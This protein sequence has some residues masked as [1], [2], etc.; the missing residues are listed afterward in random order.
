MR[1]RFAQ[2]GGF[3]GMSREVAVDTSNLNQGEATELEQLVREA[4]LQT[5]APPRSSLGRDLEEYEIS[6]DDG[7][8]NVT[9]VLEQSTVPL[10][11]RRLV[12]HLK[13][14]TKPATPISDSTTRAR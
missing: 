2:S 13:K 9:V 12:A 3:A 8:Q 4:D 14:L 1:V 7:Q 10:Q 6:I 5:G 11:A